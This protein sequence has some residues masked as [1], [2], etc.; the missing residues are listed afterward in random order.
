MLAATDGLTG[1][2]NRRAYEER[3]NQEWKRA[4]RGE[5][6]LALLVL[7][8]DF[9]KSYNDYYGHQGGDEV[10]Q[11]IATCIWQQM[12]RPADFGARYGGEEFVMLLPET[13]LTGAL[14]IAERIRSEVAGLS[15][16]HVGDSTGQATVS[17]GVAATY[18]VL[19]ET[20]GS[21]VKAADMALYAAKHSGRNRVSSVG[22]DVPH[23]A[24]AT[25]SLA[26]DRSRV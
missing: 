2:A 16:P 21:L 26:C 6:S 24:L 8:A 5:T 4:I 10:L 11:K 13:D 9:F 1:L 14:A 18:P 17:V 20:E 19:G 22:S 15:I 3:L 7:D 23:S 25:L 12:Q